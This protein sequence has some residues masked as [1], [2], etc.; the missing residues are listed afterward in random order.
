MSECYINI[1]IAWW[2][3]QALRGS[4]WA[5]RI[6]SNDFWRERGK[7]RRQP[8]AIY[9]FSPLDGWR[10]RNDGVPQAVVID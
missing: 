10:H 9:D 2:H 7:W 3:I 5:W 1:R 6:S 4:L 8:V